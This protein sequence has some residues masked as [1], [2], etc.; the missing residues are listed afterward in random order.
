VPAEQDRTG[1]GRLEPATP[2]PEVR[3]GAVPGG[4]MPREAGSW[5]FAAIGDYGRDN[6]HQTAVTQNIARSG[7]SLLLTLGDNAYPRGSEEDFAAGVDPGHLLGGLRSRIAM[8]P[9]L[10]NHDVHEPDAGPYFRRFPEL[11][12]AR[13]YSFDQGGVHFSALDST[14]SLAPD[15][16]QGTWLA[17]DLAAA[18]DA[19]WQVVYLHHP[20]ATTQPRA[21]DSQRGAQLGPLLAEE[22]VDLVLTGHEHFYERTPLAGTGATHV[23]AGTGGTELTDMLAPQA[24]SS[25]WRE[26]T[27]GHV[28]VEVQA[29]RLVGRYVREDGTVADTFAIP[30]PGTQVPHPA[31]PAR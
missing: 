5:S 8:R 2:A 11:G 7:A 29:D 21:A 6:A 4:P 10:G 25:A 16:P 27:Y 19:R 20:L 28:D 1:N 18:R 23:I 14:Q 26:V 15:S 30:A 12:G 13:Y 24:P 9:T 22:G 31:P 3:P 17:R